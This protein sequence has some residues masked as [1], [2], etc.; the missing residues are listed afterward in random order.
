MAK[1]KKNE[2][3]EQFELRKDLA[4]VRI[5]LR[6][7]FMQSAP[8]RN[9]L[10]RAT[11]RRREG[12]RVRAYKVCE[13]CRMEY[14]KASVRVDHIERCGELNSWADVPEFA[15]RMLVGE[16]GLQVLCIDCDYHKREQER[17]GH[18]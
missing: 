13:H 1:Q 18:G 7:V 2:T 15:A 5:M 6:R 11:V 3:P 8:R 16:E 9:A 14:S 10:R 12:S 17:T 4:R